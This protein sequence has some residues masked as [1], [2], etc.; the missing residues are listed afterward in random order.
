MDRRIRSGEAVLRGDVSA[1]ST[2]AM[3]PS[4]SRRASASLDR[5]AR[6]SASSAPC[7]SPPCPQ[8][9]FPSIRM[10]I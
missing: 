6:N 4:I 3:S 5:F 1:A 8:P 10:G 2:L 9:L 7:S